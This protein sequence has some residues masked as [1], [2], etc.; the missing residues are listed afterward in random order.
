MKNYFE[1]LLISVLAVLA[2]IKAAMITVGVLIFADL[3]CGLLAAHK[4][5]DK[6][7]SA[8]LRRTATKCF[9]YQASIITGFLVEKFLIGDIVP[10]SKIIAGLIGTVELKSLL[11]N[12]DTING[13]P[14]FLSLI[15]RL[16]SNNDVLNSKSVS[17]SRAA[18]LSPSPPPSNPA[19]IPPPPP[20]EKN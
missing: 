18:P 7:T 8:G 20:T 9:V 5:G 2:P 6:I 1:A 10:V 15:N 11:E 3:I 19:S 17:S 13:S 12:L 16:G 14:L 4:R